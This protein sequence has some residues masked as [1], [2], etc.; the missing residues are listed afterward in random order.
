[1]AENS[2]EALDQLLE[3]LRSNNARAVADEI[4]RVIARGVTEEKEMNGKIKELSQRALNSDE[5]Y[6]VAVEM[7]V[8]SL[9]P[10]IMKAHTLTELEQL[11]DMKSSIVWLQDFVEKSPVAPE[12]Y[13]DVFIPDTGGLEKLEEDLISLVRLIS[14]A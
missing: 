6:K 4:A 14:G 1:M 13:E 9:E 3:S 11:M 5:A 2:Q 7:L 8:A 12:D 10:A